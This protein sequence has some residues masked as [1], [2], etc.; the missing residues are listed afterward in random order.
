[1]CPLFQSAAVKVL[2]FYFNFIQDL[3]HIRYT[4]SHLLRLLALR[5]AVYSTL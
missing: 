4:G 5:W 2:A 1:M 3:L